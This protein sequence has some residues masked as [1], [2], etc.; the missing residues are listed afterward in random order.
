MA[1]FSEIIF[2]DYFVQ[3][4]IFTNVC[5]LKCFDCTYE[6]T[7]VNSIAGEEAFCSKFKNDILMPPFLQEVLVSYANE[8]VGKEC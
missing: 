6:R 2:W 5:S 7:K 1:I 3:C 4:P 8:M